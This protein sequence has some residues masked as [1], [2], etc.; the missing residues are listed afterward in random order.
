MAQNFSIGLHDSQ[1]DGLY[2]VTDA[3]TA[4]LKN[5]SITRRYA[6]QHID[7]LVHPSW[8]LPRYLCDACTYCETIDNPFAEE[9]TKR[10]GNV[11]RFR[12]AKTPKEKRSA[13][14][15]AAKSFGY[16]IV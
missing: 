1:L 15:N 12:N 10:A 7:M 9:L 6:I 14:E 11:E 3:G 2:L 8:M 13:L 16:R 5:D 4:F